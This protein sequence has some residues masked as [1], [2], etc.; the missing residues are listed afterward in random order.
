MP[1]RCS[2]CQ[3]PERD[4]IDARLI[5]GQPLRNVAK[6]FGVSVTALHRHKERHLPAH[7]RQAQGAEERLSADRL[8]ADLQAL[9]ERALALLTKAEQAGDL[10]TALG[11]IREVRG[12]I[13]TAARLLETTDI[14]R[15]LE[16]L[17]REVLNEDA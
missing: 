13:E 2:I 1:R 14:E 10:R 8:L 15:R 17:E 11:G 7:L 16:A 6:Q 5:G 3:H 12:C 4:E 9:Q